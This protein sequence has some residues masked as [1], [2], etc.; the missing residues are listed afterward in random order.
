MGMIHLNT[1]FM[2]LSLHHPN[3]RLE[4]LENIFYL[5]RSSL[6]Y[7]QIQKILEGTPPPPPLCITQLH[8]MIVSIFRFHQFQE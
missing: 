6:N 7:S 4:S 5:L 1:G 8:P 3:N 2:V